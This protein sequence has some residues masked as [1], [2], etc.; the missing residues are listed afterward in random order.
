[1]NG[2][3]RST[4]VGAVA[5]FLNRPC[6][7]GPAALSLAGVSS[8][9]L[10]NVVAAYRPAFLAT[11]AAMLLASLWITFRLDAGWLNRV[12]ATAATVVAFFLSIRLLGVL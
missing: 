3:V 11:S 2:V 7:V 6:C 8:A 4:I 12:L 5:G 1:M 10:A 9:G